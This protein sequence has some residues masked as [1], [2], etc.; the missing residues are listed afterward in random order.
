MHCLG[1][2][3][4][5]T[6]SPNGV[7][8]RGGILSMF[9]ALGVLVC[10]GRIQGPPRGYKEG[11]HCAPPMQPFPNNHVCEEDNYLC[12]R[13]L[14]LVRELADRTVIG[15][16][17][18]VEVLLC[19]NCQCGLAKA[20]SKHPICSVPSLSISPWQQTSELLLEYWCICVIPSNQMIIHLNTTN[21][22]DTTFCRSPETMNFQGLY[23]AVRSRLHFSQVAAWWSRSNGIEP[24]YVATRVVPHNEDNLRKFNDSPVEHT[25][26][27]A[28]NGDGS[29]IKVTV[30]ALPRM[31]EVPILSCPLHPIKEKDEETNVAR[32]LTPT[33]TIP[34]SVS[35]NSSQNTDNL[36]MPVL[37]DDRLQTPC[38][39][40]GKHHCR[41]E[42]EDVS[43]PS[44]SIARPIGERKRRRSL[45]CG[46]PDINSCVTLQA[47]PL[48]AVRELIVREQQRDN[49]LSV[50][51]SSSSYPRS[52]SEILN[53][54]GV[55]AIK[56][57]NGHHHNR[58]EDNTLKS[59]NN[60]NSDNLERCFKAQLSIEERDGNIEKRYK[61]TLDN[62]E[63]MNG[64]EAKSC[65]LVTEEKTQRSEKG[66][67]VDGSGDGGNDGGDGSD[68]T[69]GSFRKNINCASTLAENK[70]MEKNGFFD[71]LIPFNSSL[72]WSFVESWNNSGANGKCGFQSLRGPKEGRF[73]G[74]SSS[75]RMYSVPTPPVIDPFKRANPFHESN[76]GPST[77]ENSYLKP[78][79]DIFESPCTVHQTRPK[80]SI[81]GFEYGDGKETS[82]RIDDNPKNRGKPNKDLNQ[83]MSKLSFP[84]GQ[85][86]DK[87]KPREEGGILDWF[88]RVPSRVLGVSPNN[89]YVENG[90]AKDPNLKS[91][92]Q[93]DNEVKFKNCNLELSQREFDEVLAVLRARTPSGRKRTPLKTI[94]RRDRYEKFVEDSSF[95]KPTVK[96]PTN[97]DS[98]EYLVVNHVDTR[99]KPCENC[100]H[101]YCKKNEYRL[102][103]KNVTLDRVYG[104][105]NIY[106][107]IHERKDKLGNYVNDESKSD[108][109]C[110]TDK[111]VSDNTV[112][113]LQ[114]VSNKAD[115]LLGAILRTSRDRKGLTDICNGTRSQSAVVNS[116]VDNETNSRFEQPNSIEK[117]EYDSRITSSEDDKSLPLALNKKFNRFRQLFKKEQEKKVCTATEDHFQ[118]QYLRNS[119]QR[120]NSLNL[121][122]SCN[123]AQT[124][125]S[126]DNTTCNLR[127]VK[128]KRKIDFSNFHDETERKNDER[129]AEP[130]SLDSSTNGAHQNSRIH[131]TNY[132]EDHC[133]NVNRLYSTNQ[134]TVNDK[135][136]CEDQTN[137]DNKTH[138]KD[139]VSSAVKN[140]SSLTPISSLQS[141]FSSSKIRTNNQKAVGL[142][143]NIE[144]DE[145]I[146]KAVPSAIEQERFRRSLENAASMVFH[147]RTGLPLT[148]SPAPLRRGS[149]CF[150][151]DSSLNSV[152]SK[153]SALFELNTPPSPGAVSLEET[154]RETENTCEGEEPPRR[155][156]TSRNRP[157]SHALLGSFEE[158]ALNG[159]LE[160]VSTVH[161]FTAEL[162]ASGSFCPKHRK[163]PVTVFFYTLG[164]NDKVSTPYLAHINL[165][166][167]GYQ[168]PR[169]GT[170]QVTLLNP[171]GTVVKMFVVLYDLSDMPPRSHTFL[172]QRTLRDKTLRYLVHLRFMS[173]KSGKI[174]LHTDIRMIICRKSDVDTASD[175]GSEPP[176]E[177]RSYIHGPT[178]PKFSPRC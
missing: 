92:D 155:R 99:T 11:P 51:N 147:S 137:R 168:V 158:S 24:N 97:M 127:E 4:G 125:K 91:Q 64:A 72:P 86:C 166:K 46:P 48:P 41:C 53:N 66:C 123:N 50:T 34:V 116:K 175:F 130:S 68:G 40:P 96:F 16:F 12:D 141:N 150:D 124:G 82:F 151:Y 105:K 79:H 106:N 113:C 117:L 42:E 170:I 33:K 35:S 7:G 140:I 157:Q 67:G 163:L 85:Q 103:D 71:N 23:Q 171:L 89:S 131:S 138:N 107:P 169:S 156:S 167:K 54:R 119:S 58:F 49:D 102:A 128:V 65:E 17:L 161:G 146:D 136:E 80:S 69:S 78:K 5:S 13:Y 122:L 14:I 154:D 47:M 172:R 87:D 32:A 88:S 75:S 59:R 120:L 25:F 30:W 153:R 20:T 160:P 149:C 94:K 108:K 39:K 83:M 178:N 3:T 174:Y 145:N 18:C 143:S 164:D 81:N 133:T 2:V 152:S 73:N 31:E 144:E 36:V 98:N 76:P 44:P 114:S 173:G 19:S 63:R 29:S 176:K 110:V 26:P 28:G 55:S 118:Q 132:T 10:E 8:S 61:R 148:S 57:T 142:S 70:S 21:D 95:E 177:L 109:S 56:F 111:R 104:N 52:S 74:S 139:P 38:N 162:G 60:L 77:L 129:S 15:S 45:P 90:K 1:A 6:S 37:L 84:E 62:N 121:N 115:V 112:D 27:L 93:Y 135:D 9:R 22:D 100:N 134:T 159:R 101:G 43:P 126:V 165:G